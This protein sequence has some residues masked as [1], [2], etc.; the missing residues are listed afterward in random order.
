MQEEKRRQRSE[1]ERERVCVCVSKSVLSRPGGLMLGQQE[2]SLFLTEALA[3][4]ISG[5][6]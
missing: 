3:E 2:V 6:G 5:K 4:G 1:G